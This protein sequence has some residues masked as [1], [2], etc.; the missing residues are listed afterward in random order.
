MSRRRWHEQRDLAWAKIHVRWF[1]SP[2]HLHL[3]ATTL[4]IGFAMLILAN[5]RGRMP[6][7]AGWVLSSSGTP[8]PLE[9]IARFSHAS[10]KETEKAIRDLVECGTMV[11]RANDGA[12]G[13]PRLQHWQED[14]SAERHRRKENRDQQREIHRESEREIHGESHTQRH[15]KTGTFE[16]EFPPVTHEQTDRRTEGSDL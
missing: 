9:A 11:D 14:P 8:M 12:V 4:G 5:Q 2:S 1:T 6:D 15:P 13:F 10:T 7:G 16:R 3:G